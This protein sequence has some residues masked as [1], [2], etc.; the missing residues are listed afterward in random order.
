[1]ICLEA[2]V[3]NELHT[4]VFLETEDQT[5]R[6]PNQK[7]LLAAGLKLEDNNPPIFIL[8]TIKLLTDSVDASWQITPFANLVGRPL[9]MILI[10]CSMSHL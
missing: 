7:Y 8:P 6:S 2:E 3:L 4:V 5:A 1:M 9:Q 10:S